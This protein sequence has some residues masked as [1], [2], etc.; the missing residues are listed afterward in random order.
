MAAKDM[1]VKNAERKDTNTTSNDVQ[2]PACPTT[3]KNRR[4]ISTPH[5]LKHVGTTTPLMLPSVPSADAPPI[6]ACSW[7]DG[8]SRV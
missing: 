7:G 8:R 6:L 1:T 3:K 2:I 5:M 4:K